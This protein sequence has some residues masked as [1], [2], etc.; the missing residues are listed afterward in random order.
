MLDSGGGGDHLESH[1]TMGSEGPEKVECP[2]ALLPPIC[3]HYRNSLSL[4]VNGFGS[5]LAPSRA[6]ACLTAAGAVIT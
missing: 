5:R 2:A 1:F 6:P 4:W 3:Q